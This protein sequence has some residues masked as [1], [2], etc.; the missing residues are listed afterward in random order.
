M[1]A[2]DAR[3]IVANIAGANS[4]APSEGPLASP[5]LAGIAAPSLEAEASADV[6]RLDADEVEAGGIPVLRALLEFDDLLLLLPPPPPPLLL[7]LLL[8]P[9]DEE[10]L[11]FWPLE[12]PL[13]L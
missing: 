5:V 10:R 4:I 7:P 13:L 2:V 8:E 6:T 3:A 12:L 11:E 1:E 9:L